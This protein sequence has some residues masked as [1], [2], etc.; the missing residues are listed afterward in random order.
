MPVHGH[1]AGVSN[2]R[3]ALPYSSGVRDVDIREAL[4][5]KLRDEFR[6]DK[7]VNEMGLCLGATRVDV[8]VING[9]LH[10]YEI[11]SDRDTLNRLSAQVELY[12]KVL[13]FSTIVCGPRYITKMPGV[14]PD[15]WGILEVIE[16]QGVP[17]FHQH[18]EARQNPA[19]DPLSIAQLLWR[20]EA[21][22]ILTARGE[23]VKRQETRW[24][25]WDRL[26]AWPVDELRLCVRSQLKAR[27]E[28]LVD[29]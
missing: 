11:K 22:E 7:V 19:C 8:A 15:W 5:A 24:K 26:C 2:G 18:R 6:G 12:S 1:P 16:N 17:T 21:A 3:K 4:L 29:R 20:S 23:L 25:L 9:S 13:D 10:G 27:P 14:L 28:W